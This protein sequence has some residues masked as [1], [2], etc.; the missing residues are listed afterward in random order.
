[1]HM[2]R[3]IRVWSYRT[4]VHIIIMVYKIVPYTYGIKYSYGTEHKQAIIM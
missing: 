3:T 4:G 1:M 2:V